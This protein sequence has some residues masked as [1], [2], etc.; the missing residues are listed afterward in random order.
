MAEPEMFNAICYV[1]IN[2]GHVVYCI[3]AIG[4]LGRIEFRIGQIAFIG[5]SGRFF[6]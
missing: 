3:E 5:G 4:Y 6:T 1:V 2:S